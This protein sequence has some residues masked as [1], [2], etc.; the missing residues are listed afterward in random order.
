MGLNIEVEM[1]PDTADYLDEEK[2]AAFL[3]GIGR[4]ALEDHD[5]SDTAVI[6]FEI[7]PI[8]RSFL[9][10]RDIPWVNIEIH[11][12]R[13]L[14][15]LYF[16]ATASFPFDFDLLACSEKHIQLAANVLRLKNLE[17]EYTIEE[18]ALLI[19]GQTPA[20]KSVYFDGQFK[21]LLDYM[22]T[23]ETLSR[24]HDTIYYRPHPVETDQ[25]VDEEIMRRFHAKS[26][27]EIGYY[28]LLSADQIQ[29]VCGIS[30]SSLHEAR[31]FGKKAVFLEN[32]IKQFTH[33][34]SLKSL[35]NAN[36]L[37]FK[38]L[39]SLESKSF[40]KEEFVIQDNLCRDIF[41]YWSYKTPF[42]EMN[43]KI[44]DIYE[45]TTIAKAKA[46]EAHMA[47]TSTSWKI[48]E[49]LRDFKT[50]FRKN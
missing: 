36:E 23:L 25:K 1:L 28:D 14:E 17:S 16:S 42:D 40:P 39:L 4:S 7:N 22:E 20:D 18:N 32:R 26:L 8:D 11:P 37:W 15:D 21:S 24:E 19:I 27:P 34:I 48:T 31:W 35:L 46:D 45:T 41:G 49:P 2:W 43:K 30:S 38:G 47:L 6:G 29:T 12:L 50:F 33:P 9:D 13:F 10:S 5:L 44:L 3:D